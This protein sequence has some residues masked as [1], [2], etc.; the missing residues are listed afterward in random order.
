MP[1]PAVEI[2]PRDLAHEGLIGIFLV[3]GLAL[4]IR[5]R[6]NTNLAYIIKEAENETADPEAF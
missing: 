5:R 2:E 3:R 6:K 1:V 4:R